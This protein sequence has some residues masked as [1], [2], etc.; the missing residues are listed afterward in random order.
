ME[1]ENGRRCIDTGRRHGLYG[2]SKAHLLDA[3]RR[4]N[5]GISGEGCVTGDVTFVVSFSGLFG[6]RFQQFPRACAATWRRGVRDVSMEDQHMI[7]IVH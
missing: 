7:Y 1:K 5:T 6:G 4:A 2:G 3:G